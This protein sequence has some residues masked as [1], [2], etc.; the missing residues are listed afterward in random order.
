MP[1]IAALK[2][3]V[4]LTI[5]VVEDFEPFRRLVCTMLQAN[6]QIK[7]ITELG[8]GL[9][10]VEKARQLQ[11]DL[12]LLDIGL[13]G[14]NGLEAARQIKVL[15]PHSRTIFVSQETD[16]DIVREAFGIGASGYVAK[17]DAAGEL[18]TALNTVLEGGQFLS[19]RFA[20][21]DVLSTT[22]QHTPYSKTRSG[23]PRLHEGSLHDVVFYYDQSSF[24]E[25]VSN[26]LG[27]ALKSGDA[28]VA[29]LTK[30]NNDAVVERLQTMG[31]DVPRLTQEKRYLCMDPA[32]ILATIMV[33]G[34]PDRT[35]LLKI[36][37]NVSQRVAKTLK[38]RHNC[39]AL[40]EEC[41]PLLWSQGNAE[42]VVRLEQLWSEIGQSHALHVLCMYPVLSFEGAAG[43]FVYE[44]IRDGHS[45]VYFR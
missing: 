9:Q 19:S 15:S 10:A 25:T 2:G 29:M 27:S 1:Q 34:L 22:N 40:C 13:P 37:K 20:N 21:H 24:L 44:Q 23:S 8:D 45:S 6:R 28:A 4:L 16:I 17:A 7:S 5:F 33:K 3:R 31:L 35:Q 18:H 42:G 41:G 30:A 14:L 26:F 32:E 43:L 12:I 38:E 39:I 36:T 11:P